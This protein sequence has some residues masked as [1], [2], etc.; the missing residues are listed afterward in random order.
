MSL[1]E[2]R[3]HATHILATVGGHIIGKPVP[4]HDHLLLEWIV[5]M[6]EIHFDHHLTQIRMAPAQHPTVAHVV[7]HVHVQGVAIP[8]YEIHHLRTMP[9][10]VLRLHAEHLYKTLGS[11]LL[12]TP[13][14]SSDAL[15]LEWVQSAH[16]VHIHPLRAQALPHA[17]PHVYFRGV[18]LPLYERHHLEALPMHHLRAH[19][20]H[21]YNTVGRIGKPVPVHDH[22]LLEWVVEMHSLHLERPHLGSIRTVPVAHPVAHAVPHVH[23]QGVPIPLYEVHHLRSLPTTVLRTHAEHV[24][25]VISPCGVLRTCVPVNDEHLVEWLW[26]IHTQHLHPLREQAIPHAVRHIYIRGTPLPVYEKHHLETFS[27]KQL[28]AHAYYLHQTVDAIKPVPDYDHML[29]DWIL[30]VHSAHLHHHLPPILG[31]ADTMTV[32]K[33]MISL[34]ALRL[35]DLEPMSPDEVQRVLLKVLIKR[36]FRAS[37]KSLKKE[38]TLEI[39]W[40]DIIGLDGEPKPIVPPGLPPSVVRQFG[41]AKDLGERYFNFVEESNAEVDTHRKRLEKLVERVHSLRKIACELTAEEKAAMKTIEEQ[42]V[43]LEELNA[44]SLELEKLVTSLFQ[45]K[46]QFDQEMPI[47]RDAIEIKRQNTELY[48]SQI[49][50]L[51]LNL[52]DLRRRAESTEAAHAQRIRKVLLQWDTTSGSKRIAAETFARVDSNHDGRLEYEEILK[53]VRLIFKHNQVDVPDWPEN[54]WYELYRVCGLDSKRSIDV[55]DSLKFARGCFE[56]ALRSLADGF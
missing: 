29:L 3:D 14:P 5:E 50:R 47:I 1:S 11:S 39:N 4:I 24:Y 25:R 20:E 53:F 17:V 37:A 45:T 55:C 16:E 6:H 40:D 12:R 36:G 19:A 10:T 32:D 28:R 34:E 41:E 35:K 30:E 9:V 56:A 46:E 38:S 22:L 18:P 2:L 49:D 21:F 51:E 26:E 8:L 27:R 52:E 31:N 54:I 15:L 13:I 48:K 23:Y 7:P 33:E 42:I 44:Q 43:R